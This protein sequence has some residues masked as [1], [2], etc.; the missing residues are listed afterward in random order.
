MSHRHSGVSDPTNG[1]YNQD[2]TRTFHNTTY[3][4]EERLSIFSVSNT[5]AG[6]PVISAV[7]GQSA[8][9]CF[10][11][12]QVAAFSGLDNA[13]SGSFDVFASSDVSV[14]GSSPTTGPS[15]NTTSTSQLVFSVLMDSGDNSTL[16]AESG[17]TLAGKHDTDGVTSGAVA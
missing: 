4:C 5:T 13:L 10:G 8:G 1:A 15:P 11:G 6:T 7:V 12:M 16:A 14:S 9:S 17:S 3:N 2:L